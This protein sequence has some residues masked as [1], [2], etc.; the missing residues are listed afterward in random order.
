MLR[1]DQ[2]SDVL[3]F[4]FQLDSLSQ[5]WMFDH[6]YTQFRH[7]IRLAPALVERNYCVGR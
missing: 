6:I 5:A 3:E 4:G 2:V 1:P 7:E